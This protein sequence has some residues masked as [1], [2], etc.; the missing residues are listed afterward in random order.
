MSLL[1]TSDTQAPEIIKPGKWWIIQVRTAANYEEIKY[2]LYCT[3]GHRAGHS[4]DKRCYTMRH[5][6][7]QGRKNRKKVYRPRRWELSTPWHQRKPYRFADL[8]D[9]K[10]TA[11]SNVVVD[12]MNENDGILEIV[13]VDGCLYSGEGVSEKLFERQFQTTNA[14]KILALECALG[15]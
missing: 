14:M 15:G 2:Y 1:K 11:R 4:G 13:E 3:N 9:V 12:W 8:S 5:I 10:A 7:G 6:K